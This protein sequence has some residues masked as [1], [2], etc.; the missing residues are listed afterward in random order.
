MKREPIV[1]DY[2]TKTPHTIGADQTVA[3]ARHVMRSHGIRHS[4]V[5]QDALRGRAPGRAA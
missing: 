2:M 1:S 3:Q 4:P 5:L